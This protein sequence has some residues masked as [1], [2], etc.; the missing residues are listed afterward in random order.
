[1]MYDN[2][3]IVVYKY[4]S[5]DYYIKLNIQII[6]C[7][8]GCVLVLKF[9]YKNFEALVCFSH[10]LYTTKQYTALVCIAVHYYV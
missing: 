9:V 7:E 2:V 5:M 10:A 4:S 1:M 6:R 8:S 3:H